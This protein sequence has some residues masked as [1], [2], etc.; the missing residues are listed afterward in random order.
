MGMGEQISIMMNGDMEL[1]ISQL[2]GEEPPEAS[3]EVRRLRLL[4]VG[5]LILKWMK[6]DIGEN[7]PGFAEK[8][9]ARSREMGRILRTIVP[10]LYDDR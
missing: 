6:Q 2:A 8:H 3:L 9:A 7:I 5:L 1:T 10:E 4:N